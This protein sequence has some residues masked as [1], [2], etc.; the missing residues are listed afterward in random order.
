MMSPDACLFLAKHL[1]RV[2]PC[3]AEGRQQGS[4]KRDGNKSEQGTDGDAHLDRRGLIE[5]ATGECGRYRDE[6]NAGNRADGQHGKRVAQD[7][8]ENMGAG[9][10][11]C[12]PYSHLG[13]SFLD[14]Q[15]KNSKEPDAAEE[16]RNCGENAAELGN[17]PFAAEGLIDLIRER[18]KDHV[19]SRWREASERTAIGADG[20][21]GAPTADEKDEVVVVYACCDRGLRCRKVD[22]RRRGISQR[23]VARVFH[24]A[25]DAA[26]G[27]ELIFSTSRVI[28]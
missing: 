28:C 8:S 6:Y 10:A 22:R 14:S 18:K 16:K 20:V 26:V 1:N 19:S 15:R 9:S 23:R 17:Q 21:A 12:Q 13:A 25:Y 2:E 24:D 4:E 5:E 7:K 27:R 3:R 11:D